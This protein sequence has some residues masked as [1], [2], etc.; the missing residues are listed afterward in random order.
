MQHSVFI[1]CAF[2]ISILFNSIEAN[3]QTHIPPGDVSG[4]WNKVNSPYYIDG[5]IRIPIGDKLIIEPGVKVIFTGHY[6][7]IVNGILEAIGNERDSIYFF[8]SDTSVG[9]HG[10]RFI[11]AEDVSNLQYCILEYGKSP[12]QNMFTK[13]ASIIIEEFG[14]DSFL[15]N[16]DDFTPFDSNNL[17]LLIIKAIDDGDKSFNKYWDYLGG[18]IFAYRSNPIIKFCTIKNNTVLLGG[19]GIMCFNHSD[20]L[21]SYCRI[22]NNNTVKGRGGGIYCLHY[23]NP[24]IVNC[25]ITGN[26]AGHGGGLSCSKYSSPLIENCYIEGNIADSQGGGID[27][28]NYSNPLID[29]C[30]VRNNV[31]GTRGGG[32]SFYTSAK[33]IVQN[34]IIYGNY[35]PL[36][37]GIYIDEFYNEY[38]EQ[39]GKIDIKLTDVRIANNSAEYGGGLWIRDTMGE[40]IN[41]TI[42]NNR[43]IIGGGVHIEHNPHSFKF[44]E[45]RLCNVYMNFAKIMGNDFFRLGGEVPLEIHLDT[46]TV[47]HYSALN[48]E[49]VEKFPL[50]IKNFKLA[51]VNADLYVNPEGNDSNSGLSTSDP[52]KSLKIALLKILAD[53]T[54]PRTIY[55]DE[56]EYIFS[57]TNDVLMLNK[58][59]YVSLKGMGF[60]EVI[61]GTDR[62]TVYSPWW[63]TTWAFMIY[64]F[65]FISV[66]LIL[67]NVRMRR[68]KINS[69]LEKERF[70]AEKLHEVDEMKSRFFANLSHEFRTP[71]TLIFGPAKD[72]VDKAKDVKIKENAGIIKRNATRLYGLVNQLLDLSKLEAGK[73]RLEASEQNIMPLLKGYV[74]SFSSL[75]ERK[76]ITLN[77]NTIEENLNVY[78]DK[79]KVEKIINNLLSNAFKFTPEGGKIDF[80]VEKLIEDA[81]IRIADNGIGIEKERKDKIFDRF[82][83][84]DGSHTREGE[85]T[86]IGLA[87][88]KELV[89]LHK[90]KIEV[91][92]EYGKGTTFKVLLPLGKD[93]LKAE[94]IIEKETKEDVV[95]TIEE[96]DLVLEDENRK[97]KPDIDVLLETG[98]P[99]LL[100]VEDNSDVRKYIISHLEDNYR[101]QD[102]VDGEDGI[103]EALKHIPDLI[104]SDIMMPKMDGIELCEKL[105]TDE[106]TSH[107]PVI[108]LTAKATNQD[109]IEGLE[110]G[111]DDYIMKPFDAEVLKVRIK[112]LIEQRRKLR[113]HFKKE[114]LIELEDKEITS[115]DRK[116]LKKTVKTINEHL[117][118]T[119]FSVELLA[120]EISMSRRNLDRKLVALTGDSPGDLIRRLRLIYASKLL[121]QKFGNISE[122]AL[123]VGFS[124]PAHFSKCFREQFGLT[125]SEY[126]TS[127]INHLHTRK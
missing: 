1:C 95:A 81:E 125:P 6:K 75:A 70:E 78:V 34:S 51:Q 46:F 8:P 98:K 29:S 87:L 107:I 73:M 84:V 53:S 16:S 120:D 93:H 88:T 100:I 49:P 76:K 108:L 23:S 3:S 115:I 39:I 112:N 82:Y 62:I 118:D 99:L 61:F 33:P 56:G 7:L 26:H 97:E 60:T 17:I 116:F 54:V 50:T 69:E 83:Q 2:L 103:Q 57:E 117:S 123:E 25:K 48:A 10:L 113:E 12:M 126:E 38:R 66:I 114:G 110:T 22:F 96:T 47:Q 4:T 55:M 72:I 19:G 27:I 41:V 68:V 119:S 13:P 37:G 15:V 111:A 67:W 65:T 32:I 24:E 14:S 106:R 91:E 63:I 45:K 86:G 58:H 52:L 18:A 20:L 122:I 105:K 74:L 11:E 94:E 71:L 101:I 5:E 89:E 85:G 90:G 28:Q 30:V 124:N 44:S 40:L 35:S 9:W 127:I 42:C 109:K 102:A 92:S 121:T 36:G 104:I 80:T 64:V 31:G 79:D 77:F 43:A 59:K 21:I